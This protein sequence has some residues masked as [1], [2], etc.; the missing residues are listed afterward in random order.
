MSKYWKCISNISL[1]AFILSFALLA[2]RNSHQK[3][4]AENTTKVELRLECPSTILPLV[5]EIVD[6][7]HLAQKDIQI[8]LK[9]FPANSKQPT[10]AFDMHI[11]FAIHDE[12][13]SPMVFAYDEMVIAYS[14]KSA[15]RK[16]IKSGNWI[17]VLLKP[18]VILGRLLPDSELLGVHTLITLQLSETFYQHKS[19]S[20][21]LLERKNAYFVRPTVNQIIQLLQTHLI[22]YA[23]M[24]ASQA[25]RQHLLFLQLPNEINLSKP[26]LS[27]EYAKVKCD[28][29]SVTSTPF[30]VKTSTPLEYTV[31]VSEQTQYKK[32]C[33]VFVDYLLTHASSI[34]CQKGQ[35]PALEV[36]MEDD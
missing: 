6:S 27:D 20:A 2:C 15:Y 31:S 13:S 4:E 16:V 12:N 24:Y 3:Q 36:S 8:S 10:G 17:D 9:G 34:I 32:Y 11:G 21:K 29:S 1:S 5:S 18:D 7:F 22:D 23:F 35:K 30:K 28:F 19:G 25:K 26:E 14:N 33:N